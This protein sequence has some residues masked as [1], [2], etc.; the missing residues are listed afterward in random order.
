V[1]AAGDRFGASL[2]VVIDAS[3]GFD[4]LAIG[5]PGEDAG[6]VDAGA[7]QLVYGSAAGLS[8]TAGPAG[9]ELFS[10]ATLGIAGDGAEVGD[11]FGS[12]LS[13]GR[14]DSSAFYSLVIGASL[15]DVGATIDAG[16]VFVLH[17]SAAGFSTT[18]SLFFQQGLGGMIG[19]ADADDRF[20]VAL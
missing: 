2:A 13:I 5:V 19:T 7:V 1:A 11:A 12:V 10:Q 4:G 18:G 16:G 14:F 3:A 9:N 6:A 20:G 17:G 15:E 8:A